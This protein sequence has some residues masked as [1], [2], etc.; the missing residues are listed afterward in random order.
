MN[1]HFLVLALFFGGG[2][3]YFVWWDSYN[4]QRELWDFCFQNPSES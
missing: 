3:N 1:S 4:L 2:L